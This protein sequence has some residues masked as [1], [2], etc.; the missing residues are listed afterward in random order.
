MYGLGVLKVREIIKLVGITPVPQMPG[1]VKGVV[2]LRGKIIPVVD[3]RSKF[4]MPATE[5]TNRTCIIVVQVA[6]G[7]RTT[8]VMGLV[9][10][11]VEEVLNL[12]AGEIENPPDFGLAVETSYLVGMGKVKNKVVS[13]LEIDRVLSGDAM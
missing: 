12:S 4:G 11:S 8:T 13:L 7:P 3:L 9:V 5:D 2:N 10:D 6:T 1:H